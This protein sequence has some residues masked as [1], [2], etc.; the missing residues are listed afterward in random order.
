MT[1]DEL[2]KV[3]NWSPIRGCPG[4]F[5]LRK[6]E[7]S[8]TVSELVGSEVALLHFESPHADDAVVITQLDVGGTISYERSDSSYL[9][10]LNNADGFY[11][12]LNQLEITLQ[13]DKE[14]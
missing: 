13:A 10:T 9:H 7:P 1:F 4:R 11:R 8:L 12:K 2:F 5:V 14:A 6:A 3:H